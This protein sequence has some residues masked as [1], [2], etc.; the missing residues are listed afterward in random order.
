MSK[1]KTKDTCMSGT[2]VKAAL[3]NFLL[4]AFEADS[5]SIL[6]ARDTENGFDFRLVGALGSKDLI[7]LRKS[8][9]DVIDRAEEAAESDWAAESN[10][11]D[12]GT[13]HESFH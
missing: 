5:K 10:Y 4:D 3:V 11:S 7:S 6:V 13:K 1:S 9:N 8:V 2:E 12:E